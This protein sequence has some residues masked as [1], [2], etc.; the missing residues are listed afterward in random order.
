VIT[1]HQR[2]AAWLRAHIQPCYDTS[3]LSLDETAE[4]IAFWIRGLAD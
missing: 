3:Q 4:R 1:E 2:F